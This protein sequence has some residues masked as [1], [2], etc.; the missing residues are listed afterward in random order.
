MRPAGGVVDAAAPRAVSGATTALL[1]FGCGLIV[2]NIY[3]AQPLAGP[4]GAALSIA[5]AATGLIVTL[6]QVGY[7]LGLLFIVPLADL[8]DARRLAVALVG[9]AALTLLGQGLSTRPWTFLAC[10][11]GV[12]VASVAVQVLVLIAAH[13]APEAA[14]GRVVGNVMSGLMLGIMLAR[15]LSSTIAQTLTWHTVFFA[16]SG[17]MA[18]L[19]CGLRV[20]LPRHAPDSAMPYAAL[21]ASMARL[22]R[23]TPILQRRALY[24]A[25][26][27]AAFSV[28][29]TTVPLLL[30]G[31]EFG[32]SQAGIALFGVAG[33]AGAIASPMAGRWADRGWGRAASVAAMLLALGAFALSRCGAYGS[34]RA[35]A[36][37]ASAGIALD[38]GVT[39]NLVV[40]Q[41]AIFALGAATRARLNGLYMATF[42]AG[43]ALGSALGALVFARAGWSGVSWLGMALPGA[44][45]LCFATLRR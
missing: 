26:L 17:A 19:A 20:A 44:A 12:G 22:A 3:Y 35:L 45:L 8:L 30:A 2:A 36:C 11:F 18:L 13:L 1:A 27:F 38:F 14:R 43:G 21:L 39:L 42:F 23:T 25:L 41:R 15:P 4:I 31:P 7:G 9:L 5:P 33:V 16:S 40:G 24:Q 32:L 37:L 6:T 34:P 10:A 29:W 28:F